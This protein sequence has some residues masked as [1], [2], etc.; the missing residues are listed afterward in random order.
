M[1]TDNPSGDLV[2]ATAGTGRA[3]AALATG[4]GGNVFEAHGTLSGRRR[5]SKYTI[6]S[7]AGLAVTGSTV[8]PDIEGRAL[9]PAVPRYRPWAGIAESAL[10]PADAQKRAD[11][12][13]SH[14]FGEAVVAVLSVPEWRA[15]GGANGGQ[16][17]QIN[18]LTK[19]TV[20][21][22]GLAD[23]LL[24]GAVDFREDQQGRRTD[25]M[26]ARPSAFSLQ[27]LAATDNTWAGVPNVA[28][29]VAGTPTTGK[30]GP[31][32]A[33]VGSSRVPLT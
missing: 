19:C 3:P 4:P 7:Q 2:I 27:P 10:P 9:D 8:D 17:W 20:P 33:A 21:R 26:V 6:R 29:G 5:F 15:G 14:R 11:W 25:L 23:T 16:L 22:L 13:R 31:S 30:A 24:I 28:N 18:Q 1:L 12:E 32:S